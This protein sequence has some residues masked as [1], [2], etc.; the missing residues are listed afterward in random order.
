LDVEAD[1][2]AAEDRMKLFDASKSLKEQAYLE[3]KDN[4]VWEKMWN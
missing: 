1:N 2:T 4:Q 3:V